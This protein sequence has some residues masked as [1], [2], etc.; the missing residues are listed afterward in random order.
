MKLSHL[1][2]LTLVVALVLGCAPV[3]AQDAAVNPRGIFPIVAEGSD[4]TLSIFVSMPSL[5]TTF[6][7]PTNLYTQWLM[8]QTGLKF[9][10]VTCSQADEE[11][12]LSLLLNT[13]DYPGIIFSG[14][15]DS[16]TAALYAADGVFIPLDELYAEYGDELTK[17]Y[18]AYPG[19]WNIAQDTEGRLISIANVNDC[20]HCNVCAGRAWYYH[21]FMAKYIAETGKNLPTTTA[22]YRDYLIWVRDNDVNGNGN[23]SDEV[24]L[25][26][27]AN[28]LPVF[29]AWAAN[30]FLPYPGNGYAVID[31]K[32]E[33][34]FTKDAFRDCLIYLHDL[35]EEG[36]ILKESFSITGDELVRIGEAEEPILASFASAWS[37]DATEKFGASERYFYTFTLPTLASENC[38]G[39][40]YQAGET[41]P[42]SNYAYITDKCENPD[43]AF[44]LIDFMKSFEGTMNGY[45]GPKGVC[46]DDPDEGALGLNGEPAL[47]KL[48]VN[49]GVQPDNAGWNQKNADYRSA[50]FRLGEQA[51]GI[52]LIKQFLDTGDPTILAQV[53]DLAAYNEGVNYFQAI[54]EH[55]K[56]LPQEY[57]LPTILLSEDDTI[58]VADVRA[59]LDPYFDLAYVEFVTGVR[60]IGSEAAWAQ[61]IEELNAIGLQTILD[62]YTNAL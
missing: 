59:S 52:D 61:F 44:R 35:Y 38:E 4:I 31:G 40:T 9:S 22:E 24:P 53:K 41:D 13:N 57:I 27:C 17:V 11:T 29:R 45:I 60:D 3:L 56:L 39:Y 6:D 7:A 14:A 20:L 51:T 37:N 58:A 2:A 5:V 43:A 8:D 47:Y 42:V 62:V 54:Q 30:Q 48:L 26:T 34:Q 46:W 36:L 23:D 50:T 1:L 25:A 12:K 33:A 19:A 28:A 18:E 15:I 49:Y 32:V 16:N 21:P 55:A 10:F